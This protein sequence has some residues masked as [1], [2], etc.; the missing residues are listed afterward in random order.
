V[1]L[2]RHLPE[3]ERFKEP[4]TVA[5][6]VFDGVHL[7]HQAVIR[8]AV[9]RARAIRGLGVVLTFHPHPAKILRPEAAPS[10]LT[11][12]QQDYELF[13]ALDADVCVI[14]DFTRQLS[15]QSA[16]AFLDHILKA[17]PRLRAIVVG[18][19]WHF[20]HDR[21]GD[22]ETLKTWA[23]HHHVQ[24]V[25]VPLVCLQGEVISSTAI[26]NQVTAGRIALANTRLGRPFQL[27]GRVI[28]GTGRGRKV[29]FP[30]ANLDV[31]SEVVPAR[32]VY[33]ARAL[34]EGEVFAAAVNIGVRPTL[35]RSTQVVVEAHLLDF[36]DD[37]VGHHLRLD[38]L[39]RLRDEQK[40]RNVRELRRQIARDILAARHLA[41]A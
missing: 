28:K 12:G 20:G 18:P 4:V 38:F 30:T 7:G 40:F 26:R 41:H 17:I 14:L 1:Y 8:E 11:T 22:F 37:L 9:R 21:A 3:L 25:E 6:G 2:L 23:G 32:G 31:E 29:G 16:T 19:D 36:D 39:A 27:V 34:C 35:I 5:M 15:R 24:A 33:A 13:S 10:L